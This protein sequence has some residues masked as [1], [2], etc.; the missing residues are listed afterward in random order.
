MGLLDGQPGLVGHRH[1]NRDLGRR[2]GGPERLVERH[3]AAVQAM[4]HH[5]PDR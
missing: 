4:S 3:P 1:Q 5:A 2:G